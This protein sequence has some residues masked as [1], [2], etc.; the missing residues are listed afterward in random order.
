MP[1]GA[2][3]SPAPFCVY[4][5]LRTFLRRTFNSPRANASASLG[6]SAILSN[7][8][9]LMDYPALSAALTVLT[10]VRYFSAIAF[11]IPLSVTFCFR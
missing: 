8:F 6:P 10:L 9:L 1:K 2:G 11:V 4:A 5:A 7:A 3:S